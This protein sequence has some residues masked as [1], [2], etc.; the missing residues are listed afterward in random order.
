MGTLVAD[1]L[2][3]ARQDS[4]RLSLR[5][6]PLQADDVLLALYERMAATAQG[7]LRLAPSDDHPAHEAPLLAWGDPDRLQQCLTA[8][9]DNALRYSPATAPVTVGAR[10]A[11]DGGLQFWVRD[12]G[13]GVIPDERQLIFE[14]FVRGSA[15]LRAEQRGSGIGLA[16]AKLLME[17]MGGRV[18][19][20]DAPDGGAEFQLWLPAAPREL[21]SVAR[22][23]AA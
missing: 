3:L 23:P 13:P 19:V 21:R 10:S 2:D 1:L 18:G 6:Q 17:A 16:V 7:R 9:V 22:P 15:G 14:R 5:R 20:V 4:G 11:A 12:Q 8:L